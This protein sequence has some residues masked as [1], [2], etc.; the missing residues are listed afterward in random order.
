MTDDLLPRLQRSLGDALR[1]ERELGGGGMS[2]VFL[3]TETALERQVV[4]KVLDLEGAVAASAE[5]FRREV[6]VIA[7]LQHP[8]VVPVLTAG[9]DDTLL[10]Y[11]M[12]FVSGESLR[13]RLVRE[14][15]LP[16]NDAV[17]I[18]REVLDAL[19]AAHARGIVHRDIKPENILLEGR[20]AVVADFGVAKA[21]ADAGV[22][23]GLT[24]AGMALGTPAYMA[25]EQAMGDSTTN[26]RA[27][28][29]AVG[30]VLYEMLVGAP[31]FA[32]NAQAVIAAHL[33]APV[34]RVEE[35]RGDVPASIASL[36]QRLMT[37][38]AAER[39]QTALEVLATLESVTTPQGSPLG[40]TS[41]ETSGL[42]TLAQT[43]SA[44]AA[45]A[46]ASTRTSTPAKPG[47]RRVRQAVIAVAAL[48]LLGFAA[49]SLLRRGSVGGDADVI[50][51]TPLG[52]TGDATLERLG[53]DLVVT[54][55][56]NL[57]G[58]GALRA[59]DAMSVI[60]RARTQDAPL[61]L[62]AAR[63]IGLGLG[64]KSVVHGSLIP[65]GSQVRADVGLYAVGG[66]DALAR[67]SATASP[68]DIGALTDSLT[69]ALLR[70]IWR[71][72]RAPSPVLGDVATSSNEALRAF[73]RG[74][75]YF[76]RWIP[77][78]AEM[79]YRRAAQLD[80]NFAQA[81][82]RIN[83]V[84]GLAVIPADTMV[85]RRLLE[86]ID[87]LPQRD[88]DLVRYSTTP[89][90]TLTRYERAKEIADRYPDYHT[91]VYRAGDIPVHAGP[92]VGIPVSDAWP[93][94]ERLDSI[95]P[96][97]ADNAQHRWFVALSL[98]DTAQML[99][100]LRDM[101]ARSPS[102][103][104]AQGNLRI[105]EA[106]MRTG[107]LP[108][109]RDLLPYFEIAKQFRAEIAQMTGGAQMLAA[110]PLTVGP[111]HR[112]A[113]DLLSRDPAYA[114]LHRLLPLARAT[115]E[116][117]T[118]NA[119]KALQQFEEVA[120]SPNT[121]A[122]RASVFRAAATAGWLGLISPDE[123]DAQ[124]A[125]ARQRVPLDSL[126]AQA[127]TAH[128]AEG[129][130]AIVRGDSARLERAAAAMLDTSANRQLQV[131]G[132]RALWRERR[133]GKI[134]SLVAYEDEAMQTARF[135]SPAVPLH[136]VAIGRALVR[137]GDPGRAEH[138]LQWY[139]G[140]PVDEAPILSREL[141]WVFSAYE[142]GIAAEARGDTR[143]AI[144]QL[145]RVVRWI[146]QPS[147][148]L[149]PMVDD[150]RRR[151]DRLLAARR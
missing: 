48:A 126:G 82:M 18:T 136:R 54:L 118:G 70:Q 39:P 111:T 43:G 50:A 6:K 122:W 34:P 40:T 62:E 117:S 21:L 76:E 93:Y 96:Q 75:S 95:A 132:L 94:I 146:D 140:F 97:N 151:L 137:A 9:G 124:L 115:A 45:A 105:A 10:W 29:Y 131:R 52:S 3:A 143:G 16:L 19:S 120:G 74:E 51:V 85:N 107:E 27:D 135:F 142:R 139:D 53:R 20:H 148:E 102:T 77:D 109:A 81:W 14:G 68:D 83:L 61:S 55:S 22:S 28:L 12:P 63:E 1:I 129:I 89:M 150:A 144:L 58:V 36:V 46:I 44:A 7:Q 91:A 119:R 37:K 138:Y 145:Q 73:L 33:S 2:R 112:E 32:G 125:R 67:V 92:R 100:G 86:L 130:A 15:A 56:A 110:P 13:A 25:P 84:R 30:A 78:T 64:A 106:V 121:P 98:G 71:G 108:S 128:W 104:W 123:F 116:F 24:T 23:S 41:G 80:S 79:E 42:A 134:D 149:K 69:S 141:G 17:R 66:G 101:V 35:R 8:H 127:F 99:R 72:G 87:R 147:T 103:T 88:Q 59:V 26:H 90:P 4:V 114:F 31:P 47:A 113:L 5:R 60:A 57:D 65:V 49:N 133:T 38:N 11:A